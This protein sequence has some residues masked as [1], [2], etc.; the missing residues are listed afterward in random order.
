MPTALQAGR[1]SGKVGDGRR[2]S[3]YRSSRPQQHTDGTTIHPSTSNASSHVERPA[4]LLARAIHHAGR[5]LIPR[6]RR[7]ISDHFPQ[8]PKRRAAVRQSPA[9]KPATVTASLPQLTNHRETALPKPR[10]AHGS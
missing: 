7:S 6:P 9:N 5:M 8:L 3:I 1:P 2:P 10:P 4:F